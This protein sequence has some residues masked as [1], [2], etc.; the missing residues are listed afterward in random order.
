MTRLC[1]ELVGAS[2]GELNSSK[3]PSLKHVIMTNHGLANDDQK[4]A[5]TWSFEKEIAKFNRAPKPTPK[6]DIDDPTFILFTV[7]DDF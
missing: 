3:I 2:K 7:K 1:P 6:L 5:G 4:Y